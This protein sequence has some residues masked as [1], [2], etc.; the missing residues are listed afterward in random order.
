MSMPTPDD[1]DGAQWRWVDGICC[2]FEA[3]WQRGQPDLGEYLGDATSTVREVLFRELLVIELDHRRTRGELV[4]RAEYENRWAEFAHLLPAAFAKSELK[5]DGVGQEPSWSGSSA[6]PEGKTMKCPQCGADNPNVRDSCAKCGKPLTTQVRCPKCDRVMPVGAKFCGYDGTPLPSATD[7]PQAATPTPAKPAEAPRPVVP[8][9]SP[10][11]VKAAPGETVKSPSPPP[12]PR[13]VVQQPVQVGELVRDERRETI[14]ELRSPHGSLREMVLIPAGEF[15]RGS[16][17]GIG[18]EDEH[19]QHK[20]RLTAYYID[21]C[22]VS[23]IEYERFDPTHKA[24]RPDVADGDHDPVVMVSYQDALSYCRWRSQ[25]EGVHLETYT[26]PTEAQWERAARGGF[27]DRVFPWGDVISRELCNTQEAGLG[28]TLPITDAHPNGFFLYH[29][30]SNV[31]EWCWDYY[32]ATYYA[33][34]LLHWFEPRGPA[35]Q[36]FETL[37][38]VR[39]ASFLE[40]AESLGRCAARGRADHRGKQ[41]DIGFRC[42]RAVNVR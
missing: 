35:F 34:K 11:E 21:R 40:P 7:H 42:V 41:T 30:G 4:R 23:N 18:N 38:V 3:A 20:V 31:R 17:E 9:A 29:I 14:A 16:P 25:Q 13:V 39:G 26:L 22:A 24:L 12:V 5:P 15:L 8:R 10:P 1:L 2:R 27:P 6:G 19:P 37:R 36:L 33:Q 32:S 28:R